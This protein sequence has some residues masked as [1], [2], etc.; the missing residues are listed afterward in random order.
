MSNRKT[1][2]QREID[3]K[4]TYRLWYEF[5]KLSQ[6]YAQVCEW[7]RIWNIKKDSNIF[8]I[9]LETNEIWK[10][11]MTGY[12]Y[13]SDIHKIPFE[14][15]YEQFV[16][17]GFVVNDYSSVI[18]RDAAYIGWL[19]FQEAFLKGKRKYLSASE[20]DAFSSSNEE[21]GENNQQG[22][23][24]VIGPAGQKPK[25]PTEKLL[26]HE[27]KEFVERVLPYKFMS[28][29][30]EDPS[31]IYLW[32]DL[33]Q[34]EENIEEI[35]DQFCKIISEK[36]KEFLRYKKKRQS[37]YPWR[38]PNPYRRLRLDKLEKYLRVYI[39]MK[40]KDIEAVICEHGSEKE[41]K[42]KHTRRVQKKY[43]GYY[44]KAE[45]I[46]TNVEKGIFPLY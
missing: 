23:K 40:Q 44:N 12:I 14:K 34:E 36:K 3:R 33:G 2:E 6:N 5:L 41:I 25:K 39:S 31:K 29:M 45:Q 19:A 16:P 27:V 8:P 11:L 1:R 43:E 4:K 24:F 22:F 15:W 7:W 32:V 18:H 42:K 37:Y 38:Y 46:K 13:F 9:D 21:Q 10:N 35:G 28:F 17:K 30:K 26:K 20:V